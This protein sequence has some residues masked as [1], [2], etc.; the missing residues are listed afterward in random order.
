M[1]IRK[2]TKRFFRKFIKHLSFSLLPIFFLLFPL[3]AFPEDG[4]FYMWETEGELNF[5]G[6]KPSGTG[7][8]ALNCA[9]RKA[10]MVELQLIKTIF[11]RDANGW[12]RRIPED[13]TRAKILEAEQATS[14]NCSM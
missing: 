2:F 7:D 9:D 10:A 8:S 13:A 14:K 5:S 11:L 3:V 12:W 4:V 1:P 6:T